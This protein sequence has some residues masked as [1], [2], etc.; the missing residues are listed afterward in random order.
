MKKLTRS[1]KGW[2]LKNKLITG[3]I[4][5]GIILVIT[6]YSIFFTI[7]FTAFT[8]DNK[9]VVVEENVSNQKMVDKESTS[10]STSK[11][12]EEKMKTVSVNADEY[13]EIKDE[14]I[15]YVDKDNEKIDDFITDIDNNGL[16]NASSM[17]VERA[18]IEY[19]EASAIIMAI[20]PPTGYV[21]EYNQLLSALNGYM[22]TIQYCNE[23]VDVDNT[24]TLI[25]VMIEYAKASNKID[26]LR[27][28]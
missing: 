6:M 23:A 2:V 17:E 10:K 7:L 9:T 13:E 8:L 19:S 11:I 25:D 4:I 27:T 5:G 12:T 16:E 22:R 26:E 1:L 3:L 28:E 21:L 18:F 20:D 15:K 24:E 14:V